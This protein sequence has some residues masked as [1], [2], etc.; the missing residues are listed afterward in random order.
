[1]GWYIVLNSLLENTIWVKKSASHSRIL[2]GNAE[3]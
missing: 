2:N 1:M 3:V